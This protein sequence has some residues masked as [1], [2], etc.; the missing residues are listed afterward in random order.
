MIKYIKGDIFNSKCAV[1]VNPVKARPRLPGILTVADGGV[2]IQR[3]ED[4]AVV[5]YLDPAFLQGLRVQKRV[6]GTEFRRVQ[7]PPVK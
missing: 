6:A 4:D 5:I 7:Q 3:D 1:L 2:V